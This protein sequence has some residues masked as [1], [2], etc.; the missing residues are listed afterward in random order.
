MLFKVIFSREKFVLL[1]II[2]NYAINVQ[3]N[4]IRDYDCKTTCENVDWFTEQVDGLCFL[5]TESDDLSAVFKIS[6]I[7][8]PL[9]KAT[10]TAV[11]LV[12]WAVKSV[13]TPAILNV[14]LSH[15]ATVVGV[16]G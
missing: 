4:I 13:D 5:K 11:A 6:F 12:E 2:N 3:Y 8:T 9:S 7:E 1:K 16:T 15:R 14:S 10:E